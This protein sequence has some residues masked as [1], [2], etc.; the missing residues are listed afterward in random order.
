MAARTPD[1]AM[2]ALTA[3]QAVPTQHQGHTTLW[4]AVVQQMQAAQGLLATRVQRTLLRHR[5]KMCLCI[6]LHAMAMMLK[7]ATLQY[8]VSLKEQGTCC[9]HAGC[10]E[11]MAV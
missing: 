2:H 7:A 11:K 8:D 5:H 6:H 9:E 4:P 10:F 3:S 1:P